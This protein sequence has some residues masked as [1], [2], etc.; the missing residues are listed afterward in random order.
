[1]PYYIAQ[2]L[3]LIISQE[4]RVRIRASSK[5]SLGE[6]TFRVC[7]YPNCKSI[8]PL[9]DAVEISSS[10]L[11]ERA[12]LLKQPAGGFC[13]NREQ[14]G[15]LGL[16]RDGIQE[17]YKLLPLHINSEH[18]DQHLFLRHDFLAVRPC[19]IR[20]DPVRILGKLRHHAAGLLLKRAASE[21]PIYR[22][23]GER[24][25]TRCH[26]DGLYVRHLIFDLVQALGAPVSKLQV[27]SKIGYRSRG[28][29]YYPSAYSCDPVCSFLGAFE[30][31]IPQQ[32]GKNPPAN[33]CTQQHANKRNCDQ[34][35]GCNRLVTG[36]THCPFLHSISSG[37][38]FYGRILA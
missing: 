2:R 27:V 34:V 16:L 37:S 15:I 13:Q 30:C 25:V 26:D 17:S 9:F 36:H 4:A 23:H 35:L 18:V 21:I 3:V 28:E 29:T 38:I 5:I 6:V 7:F 20:N 10:G 14:V 33:N 24:K 32:A 19:D 31:L 11:P 12:S 1:M 22:S 8:M